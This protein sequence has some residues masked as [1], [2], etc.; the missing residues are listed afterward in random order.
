MCSFKSEGQIKTKKWCFSE[1]KCFEYT[2]Y[3]ESII[4]LITQKVFVKVFFNS[5]LIL[6]YTV[7]YIC[8]QT[9]GGYFYKDEYLKNAA[10]QPVTFGIT[11]FFFL[12]FK[13]HPWFGFGYNHKT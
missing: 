13:S 1:K 3:F 9:L 4:S 11:A 10:V 7:V 6:M 8:I 2:L 12:P 5:T